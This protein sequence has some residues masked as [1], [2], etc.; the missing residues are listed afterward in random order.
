MCKELQQAYREKRAAD[1]AWLAGTATIAFGA[2]LVE[3]LLDILTQPAQGPILPRIQRFE[4]LEGQAWPDASTLLSSF[5]SILSAP[6]PS[7]DTGPGQRAEWIAMSVSGTLGNADGFNLLYRAGNFAMSF[8]RGTMRARIFAESSAEVVSYLGLTY[9]AYL[10]RSEL[11]GVTRCNVSLCL[12][13]ALHQDV[14]RAMDVLRMRV[15]DCGNRGFGAGE[16]GSLL[17]LTWEGSPQPQQWMSAGA[18][19]LMQ[20]IFLMLV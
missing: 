8:C 19:L 20:C 11:H 7:S 17:S 6:L 15:F 5:Q 14:L 10:K 2:R 13:Q 9:L 1:E 3:L 4:L 12:P 18:F 16:G